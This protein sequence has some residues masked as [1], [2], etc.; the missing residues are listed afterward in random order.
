MGD[1]VAMNRD[2]AVTMTMTCTDPR[3]DRVKTVPL[4]IQGPTGNFKEKLLSL[5]TTKTLVPA[6]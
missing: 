2:Q 6:S 3:P 4:D 5:N 1:G